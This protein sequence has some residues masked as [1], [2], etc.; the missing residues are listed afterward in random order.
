MAKLHKQNDVSVPVTEMKDGDLA[1]ITEW[2]LKQCVGRV[3]Q[4]FNDYLLTVG[5]TSGH[6]WGQ[7]FY[8]ASVNESCRVRIL[9]PGELIEV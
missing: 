2:P 3:V 8:G 5:A 7:Y 6:G 9:Q 4:R 1:V